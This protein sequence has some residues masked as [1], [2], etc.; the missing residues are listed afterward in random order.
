VVSPP[1]AP[2]DIHETLLLQRAHE[3]QDPDKRPPIWMRVP[4]LEQAPDLTQVLRG[5]LFER[6]RRCGVATCH[7]A[8]TSSAWA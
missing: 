5:C 6:T 8:T 3:P 1:A 2:V 7:C 4:G